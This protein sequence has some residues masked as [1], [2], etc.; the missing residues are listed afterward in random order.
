MM[1]GSQSQ[2]RSRRGLTTVA[3]LVCL[4]VITLIGAALLKVGLAQ[5]KEIRSQEHRLQAEWL[6]ESGLDRAL[7]QLAADGNY[8]GEEW[9]I[10]AQDLSFAG[11]P[12]AGQSAGSTAQPTA[13]ITITVNRLSENVNRRRIRVQADYPL[14]PAARSRHTKQMLIDLEPV[15]AGVAP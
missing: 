10:G 6:A 2:K 12:S 8:R 1:S 5:R 13:T 15:K 3:V 11:G 4:I 7:S 14:D 9:P